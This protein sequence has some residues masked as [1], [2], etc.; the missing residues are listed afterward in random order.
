MMCPVEAE[1]PATRSKPHPPLFGARM[2]S[3]ERLA[4]EVARGRESAFAALFERYHQQVYR[5]CRS[6]TANDQDAQDAL[7]STFTNALVALRAARRNAP[8]RPW[9]FRIAHNESISLV[10]ARRPTAE[11]DHHAPAGDGVEERFERSERMATLLADLSELPERQR[12]A[13]VLR[14]LSGL[15]HEEIAQVLQVSTGAAKQSILE[16]RRSLLQ[17]SEGRSMSCDEIQSL[18]S[19]ADG[20]SRRSRRVRAH[21]RSCPA[22]AAFASS[23]DERRRDMLALWPAL[24]PAGAAGILARILGGGPGHGGGAAGIAAG[25]AKGIAATASAKLAAVAGVAVI[26]TATVGTVVVLH[27]HAGGRGSRSDL[28]ASA[29]AT[30]RGAASS[31]A[32][33]RTPAGGAGGARGRA[34]SASATAGGALSHGSRGRHTISGS[35]AEH[36]ASGGPGKGASADRA[37]GATGHGS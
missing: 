27:H 17:F 15:S 24:A 19:D 22:C 26:A 32:A 8:L 5:Y 20:R 9:L 13:L 11:L 34:E 10:R 6:L 12:A 21:L 4:Q 2:L 31:A 1:L 23:I 36:K 37:R 33:T 7:Q 29:P 35:A 14:E 18:L 25:G 30:R 16:A 28:S 3:D